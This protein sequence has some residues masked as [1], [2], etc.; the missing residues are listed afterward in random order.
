[1]WNGKPLNAAALGRRLG[2]SPASA[3]TVVR[4][5]ADEGLIRLIPFFGT[6]GKTLL[7]VRTWYDSRAQSFCGFC[8]D[9]IVPLL[10]GFRLSWWKTGLVRTV[11]LIAA[12]DRESIGFC[13][14]ETLTLQR[15]RWLPLRACLKQGVIQKGYVIHRGQG[16]FKL[17]PGITAMPLRNLDIVTRNIDTST[18]SV[19]PDG[20]P[21]RAASSVG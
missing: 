4:E 8:I 11:D 2:V 6:G 16:V 21:A 13:S 5:L 14:C 17:G 18:T 20:V 9:Q 1:V 15:R 12:T 7:Y 10:P 19:Y 3:R